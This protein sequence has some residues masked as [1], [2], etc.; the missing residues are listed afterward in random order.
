MF[1]W[2]WFVVVVAIC[3]VWVLFCFLMKPLPDTFA[4]S[5]ARCRVLPV[6]AWG[7]L[8]CRQIRLPLQHANTFAPVP[9]QVGAEQQQQRRRSPTRQ[10]RSHPAAGTRGPGLTPPARSPRAWAR[11]AVQ[12][13][14][15]AALRIHHLSAFLLVLWLLENAFHGQNPA[16]PLRVGARAECE[17][18]PS[19]ACPEF[20][21]LA[22]SAPPAPCRH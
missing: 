14:Q 17:P 6:L 4:A 12:G 5:P 10:P 19:A 22:S 18:L 16:A 20:S 9:L 15:S 7:D 21:C 13:P 11:I 8:L 2:W 1:R 3:F